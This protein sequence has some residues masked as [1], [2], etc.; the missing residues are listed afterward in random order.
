MSMQFYRLITLLIS[1]AFVAISTI[2]CGLA[3][4]SYIKSVNGR[5][6]PTFTGASESSYCATPTI[7]G[8]SPV[9]ITGN[10]TY[11][12]RASF[13]AGATK[14]LGNP[15]GGISIRHAEVL[16]VNASGTRVQCAKTDNSGNFSFQVPENTSS[17]TVYI[18][19][20]A[21]NTFAKVSVLNMP[22]QNKH[23]SISKAFTPNSSKNIGN[24]NASATEE[25][26]GAA[27]H[28][29][30]L[31][32]KSNDFLRAEAGSCA[33]DIVNCV[34]FTVADKVSVYWEKGYNP[35]AYF[36]APTS[37]L[38]FYLPGFSRLFILG[39]INGDVDFSDTDHFDDTIVI[40]EY[41]HFLEDIY[42]ESDSPGGSHSGKFA[43]DPR[44][45][46]SEAWG[47]FFQAAVNYGS[48]SV[49]PMYIDT[50]GN[51]DG[52]TSF[53]LDIPLETKEPSCTSFTPGCD[54]PSVSGE[55]NFR[56][57]AI[58]RSLWD[59]FDTNNDGESISGNFNE[60]WASMTSGNGF[61]SGSD[62][63]F[64]DVGLLHSIQENLSDGVSTPITD[65]APARTIAENGQQENREHFAQ[66]LTT[67]GFCGVRNFN[68]IPLSE[69]GDTHEFDSSN[70]F[71]NNDF[72]H[73]EH[74]SSGPAT[75]QL[76]YLTS[77][78]VE[79][80]LD[81]F[82]YDEEAIFGS[83]VSIRGHD[84]SSTATDPTL[85]VE[86]QTVSFSNLSAGHYLI[87]V[88]VKTHISASVGGSTDYELMLGGF[89]LC[90]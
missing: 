19:S 3:E 71:H 76:N 23:Y 12:E 32:V 27:F 7:Y 20:R 51:I 63:K 81:L 35:N 85:D 17:H 21:N 65:W 26:I 43:I 46:F 30:D 28:I 5:V 70:L 37:G 59:V 73:Y 48:A 40:H 54:T 78:G 79:A 22:E 33:S 4:S 61:V 84:N 60:V 45:A 8:G 69:G 88:K 10:A 34:D 89:R 41:G 29:L 56:E 80:D 66:K 18:N 44:L 67:G 50:S 25:V 87:N 86:T 42:S 53:I 83:S 14:G 82:I 52:D 64:R 49:A 74:L 9:T 39:G 2:S 1:L 24:L 47:N 75:F 36:G 58:T 6:S 62:S 55:G 16:V 77:S 15:S 57:F 90:P 31:I 72:Y 13:D 68:I 38:S 11:Q